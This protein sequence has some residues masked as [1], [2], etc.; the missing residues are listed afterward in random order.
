MFVP[1]GRHHRRGAAQHQEG[2]LLPH[3]DWQVRKT[4]ED[5]VIITLGFLVWLM[6]VVCA[7]PPL[8]RPANPDTPGSSALPPHPVPPDT[9]PPKP[10]QITPSVSVSQPNTGLTNRTLNRDL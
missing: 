9:S 7:S 5:T 1:G 2:P 3:N 6:F 4:V 10:P 8:R